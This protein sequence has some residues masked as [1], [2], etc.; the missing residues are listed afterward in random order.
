MELR[1]PALSAPIPSVFIRGC[2]HTSHTGTALAPARNKP[3]H[4]L[5]CVPCLPWFKK[6]RAM[7]DSA[8]MELRPPALSAPI[9]SVFIRGCK[10]TSHT[11]TA[12]APARNKPRHFLPCV[13]CLPWFKKTSSY[14]EFG[15]DGT[16]P[17]QAIRPHSIRGFKHNHQTI[18]APAPAERS[19]AETCMPFGVPAPHV[20]HQR[21]YGCPPGLPASTRSASVA[22][23]ESVAVGSAGA[24]AAAG[25]AVNIAPMDTQAS[26][27]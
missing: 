13:P 21:C 1:P 17:S 24:T 5:P 19:D 2:K 3:R 9:P 26:T 4:F 20:A 7:Q 6:H 15:S 16:S 8:Q 11:G 23:S 18:S 10:H 25:F 27:P 12:L 14:A 22:G